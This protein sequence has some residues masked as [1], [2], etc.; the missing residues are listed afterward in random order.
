MAQHR[1]Q[2]NRAQQRPQA[3]RAQYWPQVNRAQHRPQAT[4]AHH[5]PQVNRATRVP[6]RA[7][8]AQMASDAPVLWSRCCESPCGVYCGV[9]A[10]LEMLQ[11]RGRAYLGCSVCMGALRHCAV[12]SAY[13]SCWAWIQGYFLWKARL[14]WPQ[15][16]RWRPSFRRR[17][18]LLTTCANG[19]P[20]LRSTN[21]CPSKVQTLLG[22]CSLFAFAKA[23]RLELSL[24]QN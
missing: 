2:V 23:G 8:F 10:L 11:L 12:P 13:S 3:N 24:L 17:K 22:T 20:T 6:L 5:G 14:S 4:R 1:P 18:L 7:R 9:A 15:R 19:K 16:A 21:P